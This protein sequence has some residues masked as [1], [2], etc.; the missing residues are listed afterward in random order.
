MNPTVAC[1]D[2][3]DW[4]RCKTAV[5]DT[6]LVH[7]ARILSNFMPFTRLVKRYERLVYELY[8][9]FTTSVAV[10]YERRLLVLRSSDAVRAVYKNYKNI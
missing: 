7:E 6:R 10:I 3:G 2:A 1:L 9:S 5:C 4:S 8:S